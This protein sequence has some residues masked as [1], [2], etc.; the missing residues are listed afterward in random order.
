VRLA[1]VG[2]KDDNVMNVTISLEK[3]EEILSWDVSD[4][5][6]EIAGTAGQVI[7]GGYT[8]QFCTSMDC[9]LVS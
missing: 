6:L 3:S 4:E 8:L 9:A 2:A 7:A 5:A 1:Q